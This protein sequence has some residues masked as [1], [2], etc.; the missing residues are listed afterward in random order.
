MPN[1]IDGRRKKLADA[2]RAVYDKHRCKIEEVKQGARK[3]GEDPEWIWEGLVRSAA[4]WGGIRGIKLLERPEL[5]ELVRWRTLAKLDKRKLRGQFRKALTAAEVRWADEKV[6]CLLRNFYLVQKKGGPRKVQEYLDSLSPPEVTDFL[7]TFRGI[8]PKYARN[9]M[10][11]GYHPKFR[12][13]IAIDIRIQHILEKVGRPF[14]GDK[15]FGDAEQFLL[16][17][18]HD[19]GIDGWDLDRLLFLYKDD[20]LEHLDG[21]PVVPQ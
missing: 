5:H 14:G 8:G 7:R 4:T 1:E 12:N 10:M 11:D 21:Q 20:V 15:D 19:V 6:P 16:A 3:T 18:A 13:S 2:V 17:V 9:I